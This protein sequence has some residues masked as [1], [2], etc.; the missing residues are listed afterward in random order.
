MAAGGTNNMDRQLEEAVGGLLRLIGQ[1][2][3][4]Y[5]K[6]LFRGIRKL[7]KW[8]TW[9]GLGIAVLISVVGYK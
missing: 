4:A 8:Q 7:N 9:V 6:G 2:L 1:G 3:S 5:F